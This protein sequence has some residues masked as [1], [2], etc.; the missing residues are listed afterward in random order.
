M[1]ALGALDDQLDLDLCLSHLQRSRDETARQILRLVA[2]DKQ[3]HVLFAWTLLGDRLPGLDA[4]RPRRRG[5][6]RFA[7]CWSA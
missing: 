6:R 1:A 3:R 5:R 4:G 2:G 7:I